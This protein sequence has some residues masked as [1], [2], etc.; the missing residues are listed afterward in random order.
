M[1]RNTN[2]TGEIE[3]IEAEFNNETGNIAFKQ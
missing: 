3:T 1:G 2:F